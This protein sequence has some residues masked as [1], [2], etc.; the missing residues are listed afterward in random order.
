MQVTRDAELVH[1][2]SRRR[3]E[4]GRAR[5]ETKYEPTGPVFEPVRGSLEHFLTERYCLYHLDHQ[6][7]PYRLD[8]HHPPWS[9]QSARASFSCNTMAEGDGLALPAST[10]LL[11][12]V[13]RQDMVA[14]PPTSLS[15]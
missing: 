2:Q 14:Y 15:G 9:L 8:I 11:H 1:Y 12:F 7:R 4:R 10:P 13:K 6:D 3:R 5:L